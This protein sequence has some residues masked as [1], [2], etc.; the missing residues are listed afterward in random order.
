MRG[1]AAG[2]GLTAFGVQALRARRCGD[3]GGGGGASYAADATHSPL[4]PFLCRT[5]GFKPVV[6]LPRRGGWVAAALQEKGAPVVGSK[7]GGG[8][9]PPFFL[10]VLGG[11]WSDSV[12]VVRALQ[13]QR[14]PGCSWSRLLTRQGGLWRYERAAGSPCGGGSFV[15]VMVAAHS[16][17]PARMAHAGGVRLIFT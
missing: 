14:G 8:S 15:L 7:V 12:P 1:V 13:A 11:A 6:A 10:L 3:P 4:P 2:G 16:S 5:G 17:R 9:H